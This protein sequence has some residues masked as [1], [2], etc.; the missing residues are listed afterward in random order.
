MWERN[1]SRGLISEI[2]E[3][4]H[5]ASSKPYFYRA[6]WDEAQIPLLSRT[7][8]LPLPRLQCHWAIHILIKGSLWFFR[9][10]NE[11]CKFHSNLLKIQAFISDQK[12]LNKILP[13]FIKYSFEIFSILLP[14]CVIKYYFIGTIFKF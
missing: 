7:G 5:A 4:V 13:M 10:K 9:N 12:L 14:V 2:K 11:I 1:H 6:L 3:T 8:Y